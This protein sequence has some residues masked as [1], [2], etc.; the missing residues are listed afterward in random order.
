MSWRSEVGIEVTC[1]IHAMNINNSVQGFRFMC[2]CRIIKK[3]QQN[4]CLFL[5]VRIELVCATLSRRDRRKICFTHTHK[6]V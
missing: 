3:D 5:S 6:H 4:M 2:V 1:S